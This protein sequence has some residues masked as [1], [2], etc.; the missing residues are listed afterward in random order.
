VEVKEALPIAQKIEIVRGTTNTIQIDVLDALGHPY[1]IAN[2]ET[3]VFG[4]KC[5]AEDEDLLLVKAAFVEDDGVYHV[6]LYPEDTA[7]LE[8]SRYVYDV[9]LQSGENFYNIIDANPF[10]IR[11]EITKRGCMS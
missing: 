8:C 1:T 10:I 4:V 6:K 2:G 11:H 3:V 7:G 5:K 9:G